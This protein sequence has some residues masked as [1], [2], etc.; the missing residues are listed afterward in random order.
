[1]FSAARMLSF[2]HIPSGKTSPGLIYLLWAQGTSEVIADGVFIF[3]HFKSPRVQNLVR[4]NISYNK[5]SCD[6]GHSQVS[7][8]AP[9]TSRVIADGVFVFRD[10]KIS[11]LLNQYRFKGPLKSQEVRQVPTIDFNFY[12]LFKNTFHNFLRRAPFI[13]K[14]LTLIK[15]YV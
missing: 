14:F 7:S 1:M 12:L 5:N 2:G 6:G 9:D 4:F 11:R 8:C 10:L 15:I 3:S 13:H